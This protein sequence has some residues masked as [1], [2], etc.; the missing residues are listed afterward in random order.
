MSEVKRDADSSLYPSEWQKA[1]TL[2]SVV[3]DSPYSKEKISEEV[4]KNI[5]HALQEERVTIDDIDTLLQENPLLNREIV[6]RHVTII[7]S[8]KVTVDG[9]A[10]QRNEIGES[11]QDVVK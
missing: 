6:W 8:N 11:A 10:E 9:L 5:G 1:F 7:L 2:S 4:G 3:A